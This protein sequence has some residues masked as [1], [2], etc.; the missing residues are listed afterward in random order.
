MSKTPFSLTAPC[1]NCPFRADKPFY[2][3]YPERVDEIVQS[4]TDGFGF[5][6]HKTLDYLDDE[7]EAVVTARARLCA[8]ALATLERED[9]P[10]NIMRIGERLGLYDP[11]SLDADSQPV[12]ESLDAWRSALV[13]RYDDP[14]V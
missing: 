10:N 7:P 12:Y 13:A 3:L 14:L 9:A 4:L 2:G 11:E 1:S 6:C 5:H 8:G